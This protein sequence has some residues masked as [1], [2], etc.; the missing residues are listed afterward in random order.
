MRSMRILI[1]ML[2]LLFL[3]RGQSGVCRRR[4]FHPGGSTIG[5]NRSNA[6]DFACECYQLCVFVGL[7]LSPG[8][9]RRARGLTQ[10][11]LEMS[12]MLNTPNSKEE[13]WWYE[14]KEGW[15]DICML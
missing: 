15:M 5:Y 10:H 9:A 6:K 7:V 2:L 4:S 11:G 14:I 13:R 3:V 1:L 12:E 8:L